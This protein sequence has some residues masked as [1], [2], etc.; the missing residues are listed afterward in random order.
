ME[1][2]DSWDLNLKINENYVKDVGDQCAKE[3]DAVADQEA[4]IEVDIFM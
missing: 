1:A 3:D 4:L 2:K